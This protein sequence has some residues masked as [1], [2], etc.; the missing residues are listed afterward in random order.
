MG[1]TRLDALARA[2]AGGASRRGFLGAAAALAAALAGAG[3]IAGQAGCLPGRVFRRGV[4]CVC[5]LT[6]RPPR[7][8]AC[9]CSAGQSDAGDGLGCLARSDDGACAEGDPCA[10]GAGVCVRG[11]CTAPCVASRTCAPFGSGCLCA[12]LGCGCGVVDCGGCVTTAEGGLACAAEVGCAAGGPCARSRDC[13]AGWV[14]ATRDSS[15]CCGS[16]VCVPLWV[17]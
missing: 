7:R 5:A 12:G 9:P 8:G 14:C 2:L 16:P 10:D 17:V 1:G 11:V 13:P 15:Q 4:G 3:P 6:G